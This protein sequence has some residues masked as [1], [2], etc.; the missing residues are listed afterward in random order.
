MMSILRAPLETSWDGPGCGGESGCYS[1]TYAQAD[2]FPV[3]AHEYSFSVTARDDVAEASGEFRVTVELDCETDGRRQDASARTNQLTECECEDGRCDENPPVPLCGLRTASKESP[4]GTAHEVNSCWSRGFHNVE[5]PW[6]EP[7]TDR[8]DQST[9]QETTAGGETISTVYSLGRRSYGA[10]EPDL[11][12]AATSDNREELNAGEWVRLKVAADLGG[13]RADA[14]SFCFI[15][16]RDGVDITE[17]EDYVGTVAY[18]KVGFVSTLTIQA[19]TH[20]KGRY[21]CTVSS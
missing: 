18:D 5:A 3:V 21:D 2:L 1:P 14:R 15:W 8:V 10:I 12:F 16:R 6:L 20:D 13:S 11:S 7:G 4:C 9:G 19:G 17:D